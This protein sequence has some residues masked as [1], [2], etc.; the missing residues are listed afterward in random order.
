MYVLTILVGS[1]FNELGFH[2]SC[3]CTLLNFPSY[4]DGVLYFHSLVLPEYIVSAE[5]RRPFK[6]V[7]GGIELE[8]QNFPFSVMQRL[9]ETESYVLKLNS[10]FL[11]W[12]DP[13][14]H[15]I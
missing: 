6:P 11:L 7:P 12:N 2:T 13:F 5:S 15:I 4:I 8:L 10:S 9:D 1:F 14:S 3:L